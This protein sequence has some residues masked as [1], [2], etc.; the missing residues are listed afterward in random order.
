MAAPSQVKTIVQAASENAESESLTSK[1]CQS[2][3]HAAASHVLKK[4]GA[5]MVQ[6]QDVLPAKSQQ[7]SFEE[8]STDDAE[9]FNDDSEAVHYDVPHILSLEWGEMSVGF[10]DEVMTFKDCVLTPQRAE[11]WD[12]RADDT[13]HRPGISAKAVLGVLDECDVLILSRGMHLKLQIAPETN[14]LLK[15]NA[16]RVKAHVLQTADAVRK[17]QELLEQDDGRRVAGLFHSTC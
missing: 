5:S 2:A 15:A 12:W 13:H 10:K 8:H 16:H 9:H 6:K 1:Q 4:L 17:Y 7:T 14:R 3:G 11:N